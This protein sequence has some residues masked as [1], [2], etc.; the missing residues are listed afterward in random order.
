[1]KKRG[2][3]EPQNSR[4]S[5][6]VSLNSP[7]TNVLQQSRGGVVALSPE[8]R[9]DELLQQELSQLEQLEK[10]LDAAHQ[11]IQK[12][13]SVISHFQDRL[14]NLEQD[15]LP[16][17][18]TTQKA[19]LHFNNIDS[20]IEEIGNV[21]KVLNV[22][23]DLELEIRKGPCGSYESY[24]GRLQDI[25][26]AQHYLRNQGSSFY[27]SAQILEHLERLQNI[28]QQQCEEAMIQLLTKYSTP[29]D[30]RSII[31]DITNKNDRTIGPARAPV[32]KKDLP[33]LI[34]LRKA[35]FHIRIP[36]WTV[37]YV[38][39]RRKF[40]TD[41]LD[42]F[43]ISTALSEYS[44]DNK[45]RIREIHPYVQLFMA[46]VP[47][48]EGELVL[49]KNL[50]PD[51]PDRTDF[52]KIVSAALDSLKHA[53]ESLIKCYSSLPLFKRAG[54]FDLYEFF[55]SALPRFE[56]LFKEKNYN[57]FMEV[58]HNLAS[59]EGACRE[60]GNVV[61]QEIRSEAKKP[62]Q[63][64]G[65]VDQIT[66]TVMDFLTRLSS[67]ES[68]VT[69][70]FTDG[71]YSQFVN[72]TL[73]ELSSAIIRRAKATTDVSLSSIYAMN[74]L[75]YILNKTRKSSLH[76]LISEAF[77]TT[78]EKD[79]RTFGN[80]YMSSWNSCIELLMDKNSYNRKAKAT[81]KQVSAQLQNFNAE[82]QAMFVSQQQYVIADKTLK[83]MIIHDLKAVLN[84][85]Y[86]AFLQRV[87]E[88]NMN[89][90]G[91]KIVFSPKVMDGM[92]DRLF[93]GNQQ[94]SESSSTRKRL[95]SFVK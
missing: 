51:D 42:K 72:D 20:V 40:L 67:N 53:T 46:L 52:G 68:L 81:E 17:Y 77:V 69:M 25:L 15:I 14:S 44:A 28:G 59:L 55:S 74:N 88:F 73:V 19:R 54:L 35:L 50:V 18:S 82:F 92:L 36:R 64:T 93:V 5:T 86:E 60:I 90:D 3:N 95:L 8:Q 41:T 79:I 29:I 63:E 26:Q 13:S 39:K 27:V 87:T 12:M 37:E 45:S 94:A 75:Q 38:H 7:S 23:N 76:S 9:I 22:G 84:P 32:P 10:Q 24:A 2:K 61:R 48:L 78:T 21:F 4:A 85:C 91:P 47:L 56:S 58:Q 33:E 71:N 11:N 83:D 62:I 6:L 89:N 30:P 16:V 1:M 80:H 70:L 66:S 43:H 49:A 65:N 34:I 31:K 57:L